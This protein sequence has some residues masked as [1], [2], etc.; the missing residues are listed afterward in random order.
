[1]ISV[2][3]T[4][5]LRKSDIWQQ[6]DRR[7]INSTLDHLK[8]LDCQK[9]EKTFLSLIALSFRQ[10]WVI[11]DF[12][13]ERKTRASRLLQP[14]RVQNLPTSICRY[15]RNTASSPKLSRKLRWP[16]PNLALENEKEILLI[17]PQLFP[18]DVGAIFAMKLFFS[19]GIGN[20]MWRNA[21]WWGAPQLREQA[22]WDVVLGLPPQHQLCAKW[23]L[24]TGSGYRLCPG[25]QS[26]SLPTLCSSLILD[27][28]LGTPHEAYPSCQMRLHLNPNFFIC[29]WFKPLLFFSL[30]EGKPLH[31]W[32]VQMKSK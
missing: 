26:M 23:P 29:L 11:W 27:L 28:N 12:T 14:A 31:F 2:L 4:V 20:K 6:R 9:T 10:C 32:K 24:K 30:T 16:K 5:V 7:N 18:K 22:H 17:K 15:R 8:P 25:G 13:G 1:M 21:F 3:I 19:E